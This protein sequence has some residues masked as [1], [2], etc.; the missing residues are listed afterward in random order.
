MQDSFVMT[1]LPEAGHREVVSCLQASRRAA[2]MEDAFC[3]YCGKRLSIGSERCAA[4]GREVDPHL[5][6]G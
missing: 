5:V 6:V 3:W 4:C 1:D 2:A